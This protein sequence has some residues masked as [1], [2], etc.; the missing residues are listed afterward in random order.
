VVISPSTK[1]ERVIIT[2]LLFVLL[3][4]QSECN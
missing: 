3:E 1:K 4:S 2:P